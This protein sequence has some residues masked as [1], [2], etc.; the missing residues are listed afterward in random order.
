MIYDAVA[1]ATK[2][3]GN[4]AVHLAPAGNKPLVCFGINPSTA[5]SDDPDRTVNRVSGCATSNGFDSWTMLNVYPQIATYPL[6]ITFHLDPALKAEN[7]RHMAAVLEGR[8][9]TVLAAWGNLIESHDFLLKPVLADL[10]TV[11]TAHGCERVNLGTRT[12]RG[13]PRH[14]RTWPVLR[15]WYRSM[16]TPIGPRRGWCDRVG[17]SLI[18]EG[19]ELPAL[20]VHIFEKE[21]ALSDAYDRVQGPRPRERSVMGADNIATNPMQLDHFGSYCHMQ[22]ADLGRAMPAM[23]RAD[24][25]SL[26]IPIVAAYPLVPAQIESVNLAMWVMAQEDRRTRVLRRIQSSA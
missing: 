19:G 16:W 13:H 9:M 4:G 7:E 23:L 26:L 12:K 25:G 5:V 2:R 10:L 6:D 14:P 21:A 20:F 22:T 18:E 17:G 3:G 1:V 11:M 15:R 24:D 8:R